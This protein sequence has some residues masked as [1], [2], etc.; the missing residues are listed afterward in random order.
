MYPPFFFRGVLS[1]PAHR[2]SSRLLPSFAS[3]LVAHRAPPIRGRPA[4]HRPWGA[5]HLRPSSHPH[6]VPPFAPRPLS[7]GHFAAAHPFGLALRAALH[8]SGHRFS[9]ARTPTA[10]APL[11][12][13]P[14]AHRRCRASAPHLKIG[15]AASLGTLPQH[16]GSADAPHPFRYRSAIA[17]LR[18]THQN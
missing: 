5:R 11:P 17:P 3:R 7:C 2:H 1:P 14:P 4:A 8:S 12:P 9:S 10:A 13:A 18:F 16:H 15:R 6:S